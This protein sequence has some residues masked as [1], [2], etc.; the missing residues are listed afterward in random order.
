MSVVSIKK[1]FTHKPQ[2]D[3]ILSESFLCETSAVMLALHFEGVKILHFIIREKKM[4]QIFYACAYDTETKTCCVVDADKFQANCYAH[5]GAVHSMHYLLRQK[6]YRIMWG[7]DYIVIDDNLTAFSRTE[8]FLGI[9]TYKGYE[10]FE[11]NN[12]DLQS[13]SYYDKVKFIGEMRKSWTRLNVWDDALKYFSEEKN[14][15]VKYSG[16]LLNHN[17]KL[18]VDLANYYQQSKFLSDNGEDMSID[19]VPVLTETGG[20]TQMALFNGV[21]AD[22]TEELAGK[23]CGD[24][25]Q[26]VD[27]MPEDYNLINC[28]FAE[29]WCRAKYCYRTFGVDD[30]GYLLNDSDGRRFKASALNVFGKRGPSCYIKV[31][32]TEDELKYLPVEVS[33][34]KSISNI[35]DDRREEAIAKILLQTTLSI[36]QISEATGLSIE[37]IQTL[38]TN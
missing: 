21:S 34:G 20:G 4:G 12:K 27:K 33:E 1:Y 25:L 28:C 31:E 23:W 29:I 3:K 11:M 24:L 8:D 15:S 26:I 16:F 18:A 36:E 32:I 38:K 19:T 17:K 2:L 5:S 13:K 6:P 7:G 30:S 35:E 9:S 22:S 14:Y 10:S 37:E